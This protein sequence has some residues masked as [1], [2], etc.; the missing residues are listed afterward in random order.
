MAYKNSSSDAHLSPRLKEILASL[1][2]PAQH[3][4]SLKK[5]SHVLSYTLEDAKAKNIERGWLILMTCALA[6]ANLTTVAVDHLYRLATQKDPED[7]A[8]RH[9]LAD[10]VD[11]AALMREAVLKSTLFIGV[12]RTI[13]AMARLHEALEDDVKDNLRTSELRTLENIN[14]FK[15]R[16]NALADSIYGPQSDGMRAKLRSYHPDFTE[17]ITQ[18]YAAV[19]ASFP[20]EAAVQ[21][22][23]SRAQNSIVAIA[24]LRTEG[25]GVG[26]LLNGHALGLLRARDEPELPPEDYWLASEEGLEWALTTIDMLLDVLRSDGSD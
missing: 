20:E 11:K 4:S 24:C 18:I 2:G 23:L 10:A 26:E 19:F 25:A 8:T 17:S 13:L 21:G 3:V 12:P 6:T 1:R 14:E 15:A 22:N 16:G 7:A 5:T 9:D